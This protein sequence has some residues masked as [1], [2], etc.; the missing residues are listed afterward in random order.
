MISAEKTAATGSR[1]C[2]ASVELQR[3]STMTAGS[4]LTPCDAPK[5]HIMRT[6]NMSFACG[7][8][9]ASLAAE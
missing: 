1:S 2:A 7:V 8:R 6:M 3:C 5:P 9:A 4:L